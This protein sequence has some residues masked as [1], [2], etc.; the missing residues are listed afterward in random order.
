MVAVHAVILTFEVFFDH[1]RHVAERK[2]YMVSKDYV[3]VGLVV[4]ANS[5]LER[6]KFGVLEFW[7]LKLV[8]R[9]FT[10]LIAVKD[11]LVVSEEAIAELVLKELR[12][13]VYNKGFNFNILDQIPE[14]EVVLPWVLS[15]SNSN[16]VFLSGCINIFD[17]LM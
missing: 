9:K 3:V 8:T 6:K 14:N 15:Q 13:D 11:I 12:L 1:E 17:T 2:V 16:L 4:H 5:F 10:H 7:N